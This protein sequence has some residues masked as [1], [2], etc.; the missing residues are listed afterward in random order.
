MADLSKI[1]DE[2]SKL[3]VLEAA[4]DIS[5][6]YRVRKDK[7]LRRLVKIALG[8]TAGIFSR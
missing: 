8:L 7:I 1:V 4:D 2:L 5:E 3:T 6:Y